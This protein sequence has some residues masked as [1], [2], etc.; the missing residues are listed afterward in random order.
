MADQTI[1]FTINGDD[2]ITP[3]NGTLLSRTEVFADDVITFNWLAD[4]HTTSQTN[5]TLSSF[6]TNHWVST[7]NVVLPN[8]GNDDTNTIKA[9]PT[10]GNG[11]VT[12][13]STN[14]TGGSGT[15]YYK[16]VVGSDVVPDQ[17][18]LGSDATDVTRSELT[19]SSPD[20]IFGTSP[21]VDVDI[22]ISGGGGEYRINNG[23]Y[24]STAGTL[25]QGDTVQ[26]R[27]TSSA[28][29]NTT[30]STTLTVGTVTDTWEATTIVDPGEGTKIPLGITSGSLKLSDLQTFFGG[31]TNSFNPP[32]L[33]N[34]TYVPTI[35]DGTNDG[36]PTS[37]N[38]T[39]RDFLGSA[40]LFIMD[41]PPTLQGGYRDTSTSG[42]GEGAGDITVRWDIGTDWDIGYGPGMKNNAEF[43]YEITFSLLIINGVEGD[44]TIT[45]GATYGT[46]SDLNTYIDLTVSV[47]EDQ[48]SYYSGTIKFFARNKTDNLAIVS[49]S[50]NWSLSCDI[51]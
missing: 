9:S 48:V 14:G 45:S 26:V 32:Y 43:K 36:I 15:W 47:A 10:I 44:V 19:Y 11:Q 5:L 22:S 38:L 37:G 24:T 23:A 27:V 41:T 30:V 17:F 39:V 12:L 31:P 25:I 33:R 42:P 21:G 1:D 46:Y 49:A 28:S 3:D 40:S 13:T 50:A 7:S 51:L 6:N 2:S 4:N 20:N 34:G 8:V 18:D 16:T 35:L 29:Y